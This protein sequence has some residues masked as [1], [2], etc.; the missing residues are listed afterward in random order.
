MHQ[1]RFERLITKKIISPEELENL[2][3]QSQDGGGFLEELLIRRGVPKHEILFCLSAHYGCPF[4]EYEEGTVISQKILRNLDVTRLLKSL[5]VPL[6]YDCEKAKVIAYRPDLVSEEIRN[7]LRSDKIDFIVAL[8]SDIV[9]IIEN[10]RDL[11]PGFCASAGR[12][13]LAQVRT[14]LAE[15]RSLLSCQRTWFAKGRTGLAFLRTGLSFVAI[16]L[17]LARIFGFGYL[18]FFEA[19]LLVAGIIMAADGLLWYMPAREKGKKMVS[20]QPTLSTKG[21]TVLEVSNPG[22]N[23]SFSRTGPIE[24]ACELRTEWA[25]LSPVMRRRFLASDRTDF[26]EERTTLAF[27]RTMMARARTGLAFTR[28]GIA[29]IGMGI[30]LFRQFG[31][32]A[33]TMLDAA[34]VM[35]GLVMAAEGFYWYFPG[36]HAGKEGLRC[37]RDAEKGENIWDFVLPQSHKPGERKDV[38]PY[39]LPIKSSYSPGIRGT[40]GHAL[41]RT[42]LADRRNVMARLRTIMAR[43]RTGLAFIR[44]GMSIA[45]VGMGLLVYFGT[46]S[47]PWAVFNSFLVVSGIALIADGFYWHLPAEKTRKQFPYC[48]GEMELVNPDYGTTAGKWKKVVFSHDDLI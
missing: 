38:N 43:S 41:E 3:R 22:N 7:V 27:Y 40:T 5:W 26:A 34:L 28:T 19:V 13:P 32:G 18:T 12:T 36:R 14:F 37:V 9:R 47:I 33:W 48:F 20:C 10:S 23:P 42:L 39:I 17:V 24:G 25:D 8:P 30:A 6:S 15:R 4:L 31:A 21:T 2:A 11:N 35:S 44:T 45:A 1:K 46:R 16:A 29:F